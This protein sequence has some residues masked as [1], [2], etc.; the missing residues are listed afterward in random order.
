MKLNKIILSD[1]FLDIGKSKTT[2]KNL[3]L[4]DQKLNCIISDSD[5]FDNRILNVSKKMR[6]LLYL[7][8]IKD[9][10]GKF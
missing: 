6:F 8:K 10:F 1:G 2:L 9:M 5:Q 3:E 4:N 7:A